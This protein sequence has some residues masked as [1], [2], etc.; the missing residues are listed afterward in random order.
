MLERAVA[1]KRLE[2]SLLGEELK[3]QTKVAGNDQKLESNKK[4]KLEKVVLCQM[5]TAVKILLF[6]NIMT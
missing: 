1:L 5:H 4:K 3:K 6:T 2:H